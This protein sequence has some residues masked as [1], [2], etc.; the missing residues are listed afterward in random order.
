MEQALI[1]IDEVGAEFRGNSDRLIGIEAVNIWYC[2]YGRNAWNSTWI[3]RYVP[4]C[5]QITEEGAEQR[6]EYTRNNGNV[7]YLVEKPAL[8]FVGRHHSLIVT[9]I[10]TDTPLREY[11]A[12]PV[13]GA[14]LSRQRGERD[15]YFV[16]GATLG[17]VA[18]TFAPNSQFWKV[19]QPERN[20]VVRLFA[21]PR[22]NF[23]SLH[24]ATDLPAGSLS[25]TEVATI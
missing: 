7:H 4:G 21:L 5:M 1:A 22:A 11:S 6:A 2:S 25:R 3:K 17:D 20:S 13:R 15:S 8:R 19:A 12:R 14:G 23:A 18:K 24:P 9:Q 10:N 16:F